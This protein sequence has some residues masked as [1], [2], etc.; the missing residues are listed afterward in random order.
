MREIIEAKSVD[1]L[2]KIG[3]VEFLRSQLDE[4]VAPLKVSANS[5]NEIFDLIKALKQKWLPFS[6]QVF[7][8]ERQQ[9]IYYLVDHDGEQRNDLL[10]ITDEMYEDPDAAKKWF[11]KLA[12]TIRADINMDARSVKAFQVLQDIRSNLVD[13]EAFGGGDE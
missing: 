9:V 13:D 6:D 11:R 10:G 2:E 5:Y 7:T 3:S 8:S 1:D 12:Q 4:A